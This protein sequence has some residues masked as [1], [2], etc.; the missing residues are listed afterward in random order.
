MDFREKLSGLF[1]KL[2]G[3][4]SP[5]I[6]PIPDQQPHQAPQ[7]PSMRDRISSGLSKYQQDIPVATLSG[8]LAQAGEG[9]PDPFLPVI[10]SLMETHGGEK[11]ATPNNLFNIGPGITYDDP[12]TAI[13]GGGARD[14]KGLKG[15]LRE[16][17][18]YQQYRDTGNLEDFFS[19]FTPPGEAYGNP[20][21]EELLQRY[22]A[23]RSY[24]E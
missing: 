1:S 7:Q 15:L 14:Q 5:I 11:M 22:A 18:P 3:G 17:G 19:R 24:F 6:T 4:S 2:F 9:L 16:G 13:L 8:E 23:L 21:M 12:I 10:M 20:S